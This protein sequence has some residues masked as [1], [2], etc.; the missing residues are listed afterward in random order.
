MFEY[1][2][3]VL[4]LG[5]MYMEF[6]DAIREGDG[7]RVLRC[8]KY[9]LLLCKASNRRNYALEGLN[10]LFQYYNYLSPRAEQLLYSRFINVHG[11]PGRNIS[12]DLHMEHL[13]RVVKTCIQHLG[14]NKLESAIVRSSRCSHALLLI[15]DNFDETS[16]I[17]SHSGG[18]KAID[19]SKD[20]HR[21]L[22]VLTDN[23]VFTEASGRAHPSFHNIKCNGLLKCIDLRSLLKWMHTNFEPV[24]K[25]TSCM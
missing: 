9:M 18:H 7:Q 25:Y 23:S 4:S 15:G 6:Q 19:D 13:N 22:L 14:P 12:C 20:L 11:L 2:K 16:G 21:I 5:L 10:L 17:S 3:E 24:S 8:W 1:A